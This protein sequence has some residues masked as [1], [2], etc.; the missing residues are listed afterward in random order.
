MYNIIF[1]NLKE[2]EVD[3]KELKYRIP[4]K[5]VFD[6]AVSTDEL[7]QGFDLIAQD[8]DEAFKIDM[9]CVS[10]AISMFE[11]CKLEKIAGVND[12]VA[13]F[14]SLITADRMFKNT[15]LTSCKLNCSSLKFAEEMF[16][17]VP[18]TEF[19]GDLKHLINGNSMFAFEDYSG[20]ILKSFNVRGLVNLESADNMMG[21]VQFETWTYNMP[22]LKSAVNMFFSHEDIDGNITYP[23]LTTFKSDLSALQDGTGMFK[24]C[25]KLQYF[26]ASL[27]S[28]E[29]GEDMFT[30]CILNAESLLR[31]V[32]TL[33]YSDTYMKTITIGIDC[34]EENIDNFIASTNVYNNLGELIS[35]MEDRGWIVEINYNSVLPEI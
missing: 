2:K 16:S 34:G 17:G 27:S 30:N 26:D 25:N 1:Y 7:L 14:Q 32:E 3:G 31:I 12:D 24:D 5:L 15:G 22:S 20:P 11:D 10:S 35:C 33:P 23:V 28:L 18:L 21:P 9:P 4:S 13:N 8:H 29:N 6:T 19:E